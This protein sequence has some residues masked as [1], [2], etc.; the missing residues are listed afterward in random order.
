MNS[1][2]VN[3]FEYHL[4]NI[5]NDSETFIEFHRKAMKDKT[6][7][8]KKLSALEKIIDS[9]PNVK[10]IVS[11]AGLVEKNI[12]LFSHAQITELQQGLLDYANN[13]KKQL[14]DCIANVES[15]MGKKQNKQENPTEL[16]K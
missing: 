3:E 12:P 15:V 10:E 6:A 14:D 4:R 1:T 7:T 11:L 8:E 9:L 16:V 2:N 5:A 13:I